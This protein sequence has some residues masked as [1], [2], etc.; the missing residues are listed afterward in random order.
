MALTKV[1]SVGI[2][3]GISLTGVTTTQDAKVGTG[4]TISPDG[5]GY[6]TGIITAT[7]YRGDVSNCTGVGQT[8]FIDAESLNVSGISTF[9]GQA[10]VGTGITLSPDGDVYVT[11]VSTFAAVSA[12]TGSFT[13]DVDIADKIVHTGDTNTAIRFPAADTITAETAGSERFRIDDNGRVIIGDS[14]TA[15]PTGILHLYQASNDPYIYIQRG[16]GDAANA[17]GGIIWKNNTNNLGQIVVNSADINDSNMAF[18]T[19]YNGTLTESYR[20]DNNGTLL[21]GH[22]ASEGMFYT[23][24]IQVQGTNSTTS[25]I[26]VKSNQNDSGGPA[27][28]LGKSRSGSVGGNTVVQSGDEF[29][30][31]YFNGADGTDT[32]SQGAY[33]RGSCDGTPGSN[34]MP[35]RLVFGT[36]SDGEST[37]TERLRIDSAGAVILSNTFNS[38]TDISPALCIGSSSFSRPGIVIRGNT[39]NKGDISFC[40]NSG[41]SLIHI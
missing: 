28:V 26:T 20:I 23:G 11:G 27:I 1:N 19:M 41:L 32:I 16:S 5:D 34:D 38:N 14:A 8:N 7:S 12:T 21:V 31:I 35:G 29:G 25:A 37:S 15:S 6:Y 3:T 4:I 36:A 22:T 2:A 18:K 9:T 10:T 40:D 33:I 39:T 17:I 30:C 24:R 13:G